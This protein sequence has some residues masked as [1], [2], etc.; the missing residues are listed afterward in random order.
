MWFKKKV[1]KVLQKVS[2]EPP[3]FRQKAFNLFLMS[4]S[5]FLHHHTETKQAVGN[6]LSLK[7]LIYGCAKGEKQNCFPS[8]PRSVALSLSPLFPVLHFEGDASWQHGRGLK[9][10]GVKGGSDSLS[11]GRCSPGWPDWSWMSRLLLN[12]AC[13]EQ[14]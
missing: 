13:V 14:S 9:I 11:A 8:L 6:P 1:F 5:E 10:N 4:N 12:L 3:C 2:K 7:E